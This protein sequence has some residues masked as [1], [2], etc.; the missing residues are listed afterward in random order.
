MACNAK[1]KESISK[2]NGLERSSWI[3]SGAI[4]KENFK[5]WEAHFALGP[6]MK[7]WSF[8]V[9]QMRGVTFME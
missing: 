2:I 7:I 8:Q 5:D 4:M 1:S 3:K 9:R 6:Q